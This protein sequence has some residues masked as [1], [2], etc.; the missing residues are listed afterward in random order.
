MAAKI[1]NFV[2]GFVA[3]LV[4]LSVLLWWTNRLE[5][6]R[7]S[8][9][10]AAM[11]TPELTIPAAEQAFAD[12]EIKPDPKEAVKLPEQEVGSIGPPM[13]GL[14]IADLH[15]SFEEKRGDSRRH[16]AV[17]IMAPRGTPVIAVDEGNVAKLFTSVAGGLTV[18]QFDNK[19]EFCYYYA[20][21]DGYAPGLKEG[22]LLR[23]GDLIGY[24]GSTGN[25]D[26][27]APHLHFAIF[28]LG[29]EK[30]WW[31]GT[32]VN[33]YSLLVEAIT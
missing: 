18:Y 29:P 27:K 22:M 26:P 15:D 8:A 28:Q 9:E 14:T 6:R 32:P 12:R 23:R 33:P 20:H 7:V 13:A 5:P 21:L 10:A 25:A 4:A 1:L 31:E 30:R 17:D 3:G 19:R 2:F 11:Q 16:E 24:V